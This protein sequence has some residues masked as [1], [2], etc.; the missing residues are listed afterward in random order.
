MSSYWIEST[1]KEYDENPSLDKNLS[2][3]V[4]I[5]GGGI[6]GITTAYYLAK[7][8]RKVILLEKDNVCLKTSGNTTAKITS[9]H[10]LFY[11]Y[12][13]DSEGF[14]FAKKYFEANEEAIKNIEDIINNERIDCDFE[15]QDSY[16]FTQKQEEI[17]KIKDEVNVVNSI[18]GNSEFV[19][20]TP[21]PFAIQGAM[22][23]PNQAQFNIRKYILGLLNIIEETGNCQ[24]F[25]NSKALDIKKAG[26]LYNVYTDK[27]YVNARYVVIA[28]HYPIINSPGFYFFKMY[29]SKS[30]VIAIEA[31]NDF[32][33]GMYINSE[34][35]TKSFRTIKDGDK[36]L[37]LISG[38]DHKTGADVD[39]SKLDKELEKVA[40]DLYP[41]C[42]IKYKWSAQ[43]CISLDKIPYIG[44]F[45]KFM[46][47]VYVGTG[48]KKWGMTLS[49]VAANIIYDKIQNRKNKYEDIF[50]ATRVE[51]IKN[52]QEVENMLKQT[53]KSLVLE[54]F[55]ISDEYLKD[56]KSG[57]GKIINVSGKKV[58]VYKDEK[59]S[60]YAVKPVCSHLGCELSWNSLE[61]TW[62]C[63]CHGSR[64]DYFGNSIEA[65]SINHLEQIDIGQ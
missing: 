18:G 34:L 26:D 52:I 28:T 16:V 54:K 35:P 39:Y 2:T 8:G 50:R 65:P 24:V 51:P 33:P 45:S 11:K 48:Y 57:E 31:E 1:R 9:Q 17:Q 36:R 53:T 4:C 38:F 10:E 6:T 56:V 43:D 49:N 32:F 22:K 19:T 3:E 23:F 46:P 64:F 58:G 15:K 29:Q 44:E 30:Y 12:L 14:D 20:K 60:V 27:G 37:L 42:N 40:K 59:G 41:N 61:H 25:E 63:P 7:E 5:I 13:V 47:N 55:E 62:D 21:L